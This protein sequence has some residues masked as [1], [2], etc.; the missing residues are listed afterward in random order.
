[1][2]DKGDDFYDVAKGLR[3]AAKA[4]DV[5][6]STG[7]YVILYKNSCH[8]IGKGGINRALD[9]AKIHAKNIDDISSIIWTPTTSHRSAYV[10]EYLLQST[11]GLSREYGKSYNKIWSPGRKIFKNFQ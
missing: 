10:S 9:S 6:D 1:M 4:E 3:N 11:F 2:L 8:Y 5:I 7:T